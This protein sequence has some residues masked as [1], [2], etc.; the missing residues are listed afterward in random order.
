MKGS[1]ISSRP[2]SETGA[3]RA[4]G[5][6]GHAPHPAEASLIDLEGLLRRCLDDE[7]FCR[8]ILHKFAMRSVDQLNALARAIESNNC[9]DLAREAHTLKGVAANLSAGTLSARA[10][11]LEQAARAGDM[12]AAQEALAETRLEVEK[13]VAAVPDLLDQVGRA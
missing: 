11:E 5:A 4:A 9:V 3:L 6:K 8:M 1:V 2:V 7:V 13:V 10:A 12:D